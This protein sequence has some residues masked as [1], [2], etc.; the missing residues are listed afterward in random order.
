MKT[1]F[2]KMNLS[3]L[4]CT[5]LVLSVISCQ[6][7]DDFSGNPNFNPRVETLIT[8]FA[9]NDGLSIDKSGKLYASNFAGFRGTEVLKVDPR[10]ATVVDSIND[11]RAP[12]GNT[13]DA[14]GNVYIV[15][16][17]R[18]ISADT[19]ETVA[20]VIKISK[21]GEKTV[22]ATLPGFPSGITLDKE[23]KI[24]VSNYALPVVHQI[25]MD[26]IVSEYVNS[27]LLAGGVGIDFDN[28]DNLYVGNFVSG[29]IMKIDQSRNISIFATIPTVIENTVIGYISY[30]SGAIFATAIGENVIYKVDM[31]GNASVFAGNGVKQTVDGSLLESSFN[32]PNGI[33]ADGIR[34]VIYIS[35]AD[36]TGSLRVIKLR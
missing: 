14:V 4:L 31:E 7:I 12:T 35:E 6:E 18:R 26:G 5:F 8:N 3:Y 32:L 21:S 22:L 11:L 24:Y 19:Q 27:A 33:V 28:K 20:D 25:T 30:A 34:K 15:H 17:I 16:N 10:Q 13:V 2:K 29:N 9:A 23:G 1:N 36:P